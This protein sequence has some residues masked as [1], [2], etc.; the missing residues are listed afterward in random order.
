MIEYTSPMAIPGICEEMLSLL[1]THVSAAQRH[2][3]ALSGL[4]SCL[5]KISIEEFHLLSGEASSALSK[6]KRSGA[7]FRRHRLEHG[8][9]RLSQNETLPD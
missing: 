1:D 5:D 7:A 8:C 3:A 4:V 9:S 6:V 2:A